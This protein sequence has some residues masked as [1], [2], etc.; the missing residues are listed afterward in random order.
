MKHKEPIGKARQPK[1]PSPGQFVRQGEQRGQESFRLS[2]ITTYR[3]ADPSNAKVANCMTNMAIDYTQQK[4]VI[5]A[6][7]FGPTKTG[8][9]EGRGTTNKS[10]K[11]AHCLPG[12]VVGSGDDDK[13]RY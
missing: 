10:G 13:G 3:R 8:G 6:R 12:I 5:P 1:V 7:F 4:D 11:P 9:P 2:S